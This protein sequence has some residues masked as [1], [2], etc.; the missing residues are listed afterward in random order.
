MSFWTALAEIESGGNDYAV[1][2]VG[3]ISRYQIR[4]EVWRTY[5]SSRRYADPSTALPIAQKYMAK[6]KNDFENATG[7]EPTEADCVILWKSGIAGYEKHGFNPARMSAAH[8]DRLNRFRNLRTEEL[9]MLRTAAQKSPPQRAVSD[10]QKPAVVNAGGTFFFGPATSIDTSSSPF[11]VPGS[12][13]RTPR[14]A[15]IFT[16]TQKP[17]GTFAQFT[18]CLR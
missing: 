13:N 8:W 18:L 3:E 1:G 5:S 11:D 2:E 4:P 9:T 14:E 7:R 15:G 10:T 16:Q 12:M 17:P 6:L